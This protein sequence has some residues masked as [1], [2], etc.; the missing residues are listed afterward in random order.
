MV[1]LAI[2]D[3]LNS[4]DRRYEPYVHDGRAEPGAA[5]EAAMAAAARDVL[6]GIVPSYGSP[7]ERTKAAEILDRAY[8]SALARLP[9]GSAKTHGIAAGQAAAAAMLALRKNDGAFAPS[10]YMPGSA[11]GQWRPHPNPVPANPPLPDPAMAAG[12]Q[13]AILPQWRGPRRSPCSRPRSSACRLRR[14]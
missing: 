4:I 10:Q 7:A 3:A 1:H 11:P 9:D 14:R 2:H 12:N 13:P 5:P 6:A 8:A